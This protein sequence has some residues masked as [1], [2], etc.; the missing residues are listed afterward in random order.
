[1][2]AIF[3]F[4]HHFA[5]FTLF[6]A[7]VVE[8]VLLRHELTV[9]IAR[10][11]QRFDLIYGIAAGV[12]LVAGF[13]RVLYFEKGEHYYFNSI[14][15][16]IKLGAFIV[17][18]LLSIVP[19]MEFFSWSKVLKA[20][21]AP[22]LDATRVRKLRILIHMELTGVGVIIVCAALMAKGIGYHG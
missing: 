16:H 10:T 1:M 22:V 13:L 21:Q 17:V 6:A 3:A 9:Q 12:L 14:P 2:A 4:I 5:A 19:T 8:L 11:I 18:G 7:L 15:F 20:G